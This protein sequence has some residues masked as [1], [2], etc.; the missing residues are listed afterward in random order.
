VRGRGYSCDWMEIV[1]GRD[2][3]VL[4]R[5][6]IGVLMGLTRTLSR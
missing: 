4:Q 5:G 2:R 3:N 1:Y 6:V